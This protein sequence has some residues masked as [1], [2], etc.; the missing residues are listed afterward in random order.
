M[1]PL[2]YACLAYTK[3]RFVF[4]NPKKILNDKELVNQSFLPGI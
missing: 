2:Q 3:P 1:A 4:L